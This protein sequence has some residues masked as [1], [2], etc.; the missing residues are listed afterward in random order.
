MNKFYIAFREDSKFFNYL[1]IV[2]T[3][4]NLDT[5]KSM[6]EDLLDPNPYILTEEEEQ[7]CQSIKKFLD[8]LRKSKTV[9]SFDLHH[10][11]AEN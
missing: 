11:P 1:F 4:Q 3:K 2:N 9:V 8:T 7:K 6:T 5:I 10:E